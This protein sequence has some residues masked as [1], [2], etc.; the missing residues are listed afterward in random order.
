MLINL[1]VHL[2][3]YLF[4]QRRIFLRDPTGVVR[5]QR[6]GHPIVNIMDLRMTISG[7]RQR[8]DGINEINRL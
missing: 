6:D 7:I 5:C 4:R 8:G 2:L 1:H 3:F